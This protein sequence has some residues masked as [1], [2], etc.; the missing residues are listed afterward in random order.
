VCA[1]RERAA[2]GRRDTDLRHGEP[3]HVAATHR[4]APA[5]ER[6]VAT[7]AESCAS[8]RVAVCAQASGRPPRAGG[9]RPLAPRVHERRAHCPRRTGRCC[10]AGQGGGRVAALCWPP[11]RARRLLQ[12][13]SVVLNAMTRPAI[14]LPR[15]Q[16]LHQRCRIV[17][18]H[19]NAFARRRRLH[20]ADQR[21]R[22][23]QKQPRVSV[24]AMQACHEETSEPK[25]RRCHGTVNEHLD[26]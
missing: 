4:M 26:C 11:R 6:R 9:G 5:D 12:R 18:A 23:R 25:A 22:G 7:P 15:A 1:C 2:W 3:H 8:S 10:D 13:W 20:A 14:R 19:A 21:R 17:A 24:I 16:C